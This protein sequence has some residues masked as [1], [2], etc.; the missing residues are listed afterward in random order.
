MREVYRRIAI[1]GILTAII[2]AVV[3]VVI[4]EMSATA[5]QMPVGTRATIKKPEQ[6]AA[7]TAAANELRYRVPVM[8]AAWGFLVVAGFEVIR[9][10]LRGRRPTPPPAP[11]V[12]D[13]TE[14][15]LEE[16]LSQAEARSGVAA[17]NPVASK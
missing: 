5:M 16:L 12:P 9:H 13:E 10:R 17:T 11:S 2:L 14:K 8:M 1:N 4:G 15:L 6:D 3:G 7:T